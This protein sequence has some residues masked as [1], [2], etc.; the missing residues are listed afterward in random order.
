MY[1]GTGY[2]EPNLDVTWSDPY[3]LIPD[4][5]FYRKKEERE[6]KKEWYGGI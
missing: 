1:T 2:S 6:K 5:D 4:L 3:F